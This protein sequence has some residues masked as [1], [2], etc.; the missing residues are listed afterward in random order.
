MAMRH[1]LL[2]GYWRLE[3]T[4]APGLRYSQ[5]VYEEVLRRHVQNSTAWLD[6]RHPISSVPRV[7]VRSP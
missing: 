6:L 5:L 4:I 7:C 2:R 1:L 3:R